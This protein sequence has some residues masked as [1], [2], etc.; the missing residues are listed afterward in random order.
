[1]DDILTHVAGVDVH[2]EKLSITVLVG[3]TNEAV[4]SEYFECKTFT[5]DLED[6]G[7]KIIALG[8][9]DVVMESTGIYWKPIFNVWSQLGIKVVLANAYHVK[10]LPGR[11]TDMKDS[12]WLAQLFRK[13]LIRGSF[14]PTLEFQ[15]LRDLTRHR[16]TLIN[17]VSRVKNR[18]Q[19]V[20]ENA[21]IKLSSV[22][23]DVF[24]V[25][26]YCV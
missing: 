11:K 26:G 18:V 2:K 20:L 25:G 1:M 7:K 14:I 8:V 21:N 15:E 24:G 12:E 4:K 5:S 17:E 13:G 6:A 10:N 16:V 3:N 19:K 23:N 9:Y 22:I